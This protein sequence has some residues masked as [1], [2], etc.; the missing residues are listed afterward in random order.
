MVKKQDKTSKSLLIWMGISVVLT[1]VS[2]AW[3]RYDFYRQECALKEM[4]C[5]PKENPVLF[6]LTRVALTVTLVLIFAL[7]EH[8]YE[9]SRGVKIST[10]KK[11]VGYIIFAVIL[12]L[13]IGWLVIL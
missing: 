5:L 10:V 11:T 2:Y 8:K 7:L 1:I 6:M 9:I 12:F 3:L 4:D 13:I